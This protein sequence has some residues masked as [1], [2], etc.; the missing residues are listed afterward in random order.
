MVSGLDSAMADADE[1][2]WMDAGSYETTTGEEVVYDG[3][4]FMTWRSKYVDENIDGDGYGMIWIDIED[5]PSGGCSW[6]SFSFES[7]CDYTVQLANALKSK[8]K[9]VGI[10]ASAHFWNIIM[11]SQFACPQL[12]IYPLWYPHYDNKDDYSDFA[13]F[14]GWKTPAIKQY[15]GTT[16]VCD[17]GVD[18]NFY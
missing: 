2:L 4:D 14:G 13:P 5:N 17:T 16:Y 9:K 12:A 6:N 11:G 1:E 7:N 10:Y 15:H 18:L 3:S 8:G